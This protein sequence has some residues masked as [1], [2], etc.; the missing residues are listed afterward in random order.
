MIFVLLAIALA[1]AGR[2]LGWA[3]SKHVLYF[4]PGAMLLALCFLWGTGVALA[5]HALITWQHPNIILKII[6][7][8]L[9]GAYVAIPNY[10]LIAE[11]SIP[12][13]ATPKHNLIL[14]LPL[15]VYIFVSVAFAWLL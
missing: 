2:R 14:M 11:S 9:L 1:Y 12:P 4:S 5:V 3:L 15:W 13:D 7:G 10:G 8:F 6:F